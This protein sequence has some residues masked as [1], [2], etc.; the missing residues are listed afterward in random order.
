MKRVIY[1]LIVLFL[2]F[3]CRKD[4]IDTI[5]IV[6]PYQI[7]YPKILGVYLP[8]IEI[9]FNNPMTIQGVELGRE[10]FYETLLSSDNTQS[11]ASCHLL[12]NSFSDTVDLSIGVTGVSGDRNAMALFNLG[13]A[14]SFF[15]DGRALTL[16]EQ[17]LK[18]V[19]NPVEMN[20]TWEKAV[21][22]LQSSIKY[23][24]LFKAAFGTSE[25]DSV[26]VAKAL[27]Q[28]ERTLLS[29]N[30]PFDKRLLNE[31]TGFSIEESSLFLEG[32]SI[33]EDESRGGCF[34]CHGGLDGNY[35][36]TDNLFHNN[37]L[38]L[39]P[40]DSG[41]AA[42]TENIWDIGKFKTPSV[43]NLTYTA[44]YMHDG[45]FAT[46]EEVVTHYSSGIQESIYLDPNIHLDPGGIPLLNPS[47]EK[48]LVFFLKSLS[49]N[50]FVANPDYKKP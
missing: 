27:A 49:D 37:G 41:L 20:N 31:P 12:V 35:L 18:P 34:H 5:A 13:W 45:R 6:T 9:P 28:F 21:K 7:E 2:F 14:S 50:D 16:E 42:I 46:L 8:E 24:N 39:I 17:A 30:S 25:I 11:C 29:G 40:L 23:P 36:F 1:I 19:T 47:E 38:D 3:S 48:A 33:F 15:W 43:R 10:L 4:Q 44:P 26:L 22:A 32:K